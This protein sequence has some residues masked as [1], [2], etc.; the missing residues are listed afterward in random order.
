MFQSLW[1]HAVESLSV[2]FDLWW[3]FI[4]LAALFCTSQYCNVSRTYVENISAMLCFIAVL[5]QRGAFLWT[6][7]N[8]VLIFVCWATFCSTSDAKLHVVSYSWN[9]RIRRSFLCL[10]WHCLKL[11]PLP[12]DFQFTV[13]ASNLLFLCG[14]FS[15]V[16][17]LYWPAI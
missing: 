3:I 6:Q 13:N 9:I 4:R 10:V 16:N 12:K 8:Y 15:Q 7:T 2:R 1:L 14:I 11:D 17:T 5:K